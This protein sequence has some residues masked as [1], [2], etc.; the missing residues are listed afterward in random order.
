MSQHALRSLLLTP[1]AVSIPRHSHSIASQ[2]NSCRGTA[3]QLDVDILWPSA[4]EVKGT[5]AGSIFAFRKN[6]TKQKS[7]LVY[8]PSPGVLVIILFFRFL[9][10]FFLF[11]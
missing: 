7:T 5:S 4:A 3:E 8:W 9:V 6:K 11:F 2:A 10:V 1:R